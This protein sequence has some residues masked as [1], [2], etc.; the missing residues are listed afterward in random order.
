VVGFEVLPE[1]CCQRADQADQAAV[2]DAGLALAQVVHQ[3][4]PDRPAGQ[5]VPVH[6]VLDIVLA[7]ELGADHPDGGGN[8]GRED[9][10][11][12]QEL[13][14]E[15]AVPVAA[16]PVGEHEPAA[17][18]QLNAV[19]GRD[20]GD[21]AALGRHDQ[22]D[23]LDRG[24]ERGLPDRA[25]LPQCPQGRDPGGVTDPAHLLGDPDRGGGGQQPGQSR[26]DDIGADQLDQPRAEPVVLPPAQGPAHSGGLQVI[27]HLLPPVGGPVGA[28]AGGVPPLLPGR[29]RVQLKPVQG[30]QHGQL[31]P[32]PDPDAVI[33]PERR[34]ARSECDVGQSPSSA[35]RATKAST[36]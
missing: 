5:L 3:Q 4:V 6:Q 34:K 35:C 31:A 12:V 26:A 33:G 1:P 11:G 21:E 19:A 24:H 13:V 27:E 8:A 20:V 16:G 2:V 29:A 15:R 9:P 10:G 7:A 25:G 32:V 23:P 17:V 22:G 18:Q 30:L 14:E 36:R 28:S